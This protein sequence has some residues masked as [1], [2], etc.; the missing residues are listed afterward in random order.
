MGSGS[1]MVML[2]R[3]SYKNI[4]ATDVVNNWFYEEAK[5]YHYS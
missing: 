5:Q 1:S 2:E 3:I 4:H